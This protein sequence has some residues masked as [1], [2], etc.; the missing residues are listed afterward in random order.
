MII[1]VIQAI[2]SV[3]FYFVAIP[4]YNGYLIMGYSTI[5]TCM[6]VF[7]LVFDRDVT[8]AAVMKYPPLYATL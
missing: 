4:I 2:F 6:P 8:V 1:A 5:Y 7:C 3:I